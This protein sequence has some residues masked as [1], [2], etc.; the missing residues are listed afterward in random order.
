MCSAPGHPEPGTATQDPLQFDRRLFGERR[1]AADQLA[2]VL[3]CVGATLCKL[4]L[5]PA[6]FF[7]QISDGFAGRRDP[8]VEEIAHR[9]SHDSLQ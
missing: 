8:V 9:L 5:T 2:D 7:Q 1:L 6:L 3:F 4:G